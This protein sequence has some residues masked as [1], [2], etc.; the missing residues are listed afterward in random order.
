MKPYH[1]GIVKMK[2][3]TI[4]KPWTCHLVHIFSIAPQ[5]VGEIVQPIA[6]TGPPSPRSPDS[7]T[8]PGNL[9]SQL[10]EAVIEEKVA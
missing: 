2:V 10:H 5:V 3:Q 6:A 7:I 4:P 1:R 9:N 8:E